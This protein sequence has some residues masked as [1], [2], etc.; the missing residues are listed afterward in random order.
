MRPLRDARQA[1][2]ASLAI[3][4]EVTALR[5][6]V[7]KSVGSMKWHAL[8][9]YVSIHRTC[10]LKHNL[11]HLWNH[12]LALL[13]GNPPI[14]LK[15]KVAQS[16]NLEAKNGTKFRFIGLLGCS[17]GDRLTAQKDF[18]PA[19]RANKSDF[20]AW[21]SMFPPPHGRASQ[22]HALSAPRARA[23]AD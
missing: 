9:G 15:Q 23:S 6:T 13:A 11:A 17:I 19:W 21:P 7:A 5:Q 1:L 16:P 12:K 2:L 14:A 20:T 10:E 4:S 8:P 3:L 22:F 18:S